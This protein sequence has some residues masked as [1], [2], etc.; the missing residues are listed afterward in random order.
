MSSEESKKVVSLKELKE[1][2]VPVVSVSTLDSEFY[3]T[4]TDMEVRVDKYGNRALFVR[5]ETTNGL[6]VQKFTKTGIWEFMKALEQLG[7]SEEDSPIGYTFKWRKMLRG[8]MLKERWF[9]VEL[10]EETEEIA[11]EETEEEEV[12]PEEVRKEEQ[13]Q[14]PEMSDEAKLLYGTLMDRRVM[15]EG[16]VKNLYRDKKAYKKAVAELIDKG[17]IEEFK[18]GGKKFFRIKQ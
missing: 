5:I 6:V 14:L 9:P 17:L 3:G 1:I 8:R 15:S 13:P 18:K 16:D 12:T 2:G 4:I 10:V 7:F 11:E